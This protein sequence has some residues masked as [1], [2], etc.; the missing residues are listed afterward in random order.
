MNNVL[1][2]D[3]LHPFM[4]TEPSVVNCLSV[5]HQNVVSEMFRRLFEQT[6]LNKGSRHPWTWSL[7]FISVSEEVITYEFRVALTVRTTFPVVIVVTSPVY[8]RSNKLLQVT[9]IT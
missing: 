8:L 1:Q 6:G 4:G 3:V 7:E 5:I 2:A 9:I